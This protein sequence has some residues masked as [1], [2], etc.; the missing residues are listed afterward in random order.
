MVCENVP[1]VGKCLKTLTDQ[2]RNRPSPA[3]GKF[4]AWGAESASE[5]G[6][7]RRWFIFAS[8]PSL[9]SWQSALVRHLTVAV[10]FVGGFGAKVELDVSSG[11]G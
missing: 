5:A 8:C 1:S 4:T 10:R 2:V 6:H 7:V 3:H 11:C 9:S